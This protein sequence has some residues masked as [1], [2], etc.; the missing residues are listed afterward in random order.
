MTVRP[1]ETIVNV[2]AQKRFLVLLL[3]WGSLSAQDAWGRDECPVSEEV[4]LT[5]TIGSKTMSLC[6]SA[7]DEIHY[8]FG[9]RGR[10]PVDNNVSAT[11]V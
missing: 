9:K 10:A 11:D 8:R 6:K 5:C 4:I 1:G 3:S 7:V 2:N